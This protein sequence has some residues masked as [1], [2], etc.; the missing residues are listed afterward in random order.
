[1]E[2]AGLVRAWVS[3]PFLLAGCYPGDLDETEARDKLAAL[4]DSG[5]R[6]FIS[7]QEELEAQRFAAY[8]PLL[9]QL[10][11]SRK[12]AIQCER[13]PIED[14]GIPFVGIMN[15]I[16]DRSDRAVARSLPVYIHCWGGHGRT[17]TVV[18]CWLMRHGSTGD[19]A[20]R[21]IKNLRKHDPYL[22]SQPSPQTAEQVAFVREWPRHDLSLTDGD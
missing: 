20:L 15:R 5:I 10:A 21:Q 9:G 13:F 14:C 11:A 7:L 17:A 12:I 22:L 16:L 4:L 2:S 1:M 3:P 6:V 18:G 19:E 8:E